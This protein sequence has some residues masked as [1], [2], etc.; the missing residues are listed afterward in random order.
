MDLLKETIDREMLDLKSAP[1]SPAKNE[2]IEKV[3]LNFSSYIYSKVRTFNYQAYGI[4]RD[5]LIQEICIRVWKALNNG[6]TIRNFRPYLKKVVDS[7]VIDQIRESRKAY[8]AAALQAQ[9]QSEAQSRADHNNDG[10]GLL[11]DLLLGSLGELK[12]SRRKVLRLYLLD[13]S[14]DQIAELMNWTRGKTQNLFYRGLRDLK[15]MFGKAGVSYESQF[16]PNQKNL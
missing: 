10:N 16:E 15:K 4:D 1:N 3:I 7:V 12:E 9:T 13:Y 11:K 5:D 6:N 8:Q 14:L 2:Q